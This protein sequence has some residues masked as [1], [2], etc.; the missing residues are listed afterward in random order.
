M[1]KVVSTGSCIVVVV[2]IIAA[3]FGYLTWVG[4]T[5]EAELW[6][7]S[8]ILYVNYHFNIAFTLALVTLTIA[9]FAAAPMCML[10]SKDSYEALMYKD[11]KMTSK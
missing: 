9:V 3:T 4:G 1:L 2:Y 5:G 7:H 6:A 11:K 8:N 10:P